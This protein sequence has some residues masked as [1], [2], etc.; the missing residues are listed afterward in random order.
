MNLHE[1]DAALAEIEQYLLVETAPAP[2]PG[3]WADAQ[4]RTIE[5]LAALG[6]PQNRLR[7]V[8]VAG[9]AGKGSVC[10]YLTALLSAHG[11]RVGTYTSPHVYSV[12]ERFQLDG[13]P[14]DAAD[15]LPALRAVRDTRAMLKGRS[16]ATGTT[17]FET[18]TAAAFE[19]FHR[20][21]VDYAIVETGIGGLRDATN[22]VSRQDKLAVLTTIGFDH[23]DVLGD[24]LS[25][26]A[27]QKAGILPWRGTAI[28]LTGGPDI[29]RT[30]S[31]IAAA[32]D[33]TLHLLTP[34]AIAGVVTGLPG[35]VTV[36]G[37]Q[38]NNA[39][40]ALHAASRLATR[41]N[42][43]MDPVAS[44][45]AL[46]EMRLPGRFEIR[47]WD[48]RE[49]VLD[50]AHNPLKLRAVVELLR[51]RYG[52]RRRPVWVVGI[53]D[54]KNAREMFDVLASHA[55]TVVA[56]EFRTE[57]RRAGRGT[58]A[59]AEDLAA[60]AIGAGLE[61]VTVEPSMPAALRCAAGLSSPHDPIVVTGSFFTVAEASEAMEL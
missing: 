56:T 11:F 9:T 38:Q 52:S 29:D 41:D 17:M 54:G 59:R 57:G 4:A 35:P 20:R 13:A 15:F 33:C 1:Q 7:V 25:A 46:R 6:Q 26:I 12:M 32:R 22:V 51:R 30:I 8:H 31:D 39:G 28:A 42:W 49:V 14:G 27:T 18:A 43:R 50:G 2:R 47:Q 61:S 36:H 10:Q 44:G 58:V 34:R 53:K 5:L 21:Q 37:H 40:L 23:A 3:L 60:V 55:T 48:G 45:T 24:T 19:Y 16:A